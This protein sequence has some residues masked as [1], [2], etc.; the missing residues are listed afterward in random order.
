MTATKG[1]DG[2]MRRIKFLGLAAVVLVAAL[3]ARPREA[4]IARD[5]LAVFDSED[6]IKALRPD[7]WAKAGA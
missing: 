4:L 5:V 1:A 2:D 7:L 6:E 3:G